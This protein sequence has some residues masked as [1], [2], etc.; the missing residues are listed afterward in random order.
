M[1][2][3]SPPARWQQVSL[4]C[5]SWQT[6]EAT[7]IT[8]LAPLMATAEDARLTACW[9]FSRKGPC[10]RLRIL[11]ATGHDEEAAAFISDLAGR[12]TREQAAERCPQ[13]IYEPEIHAFGGD[14]AMDIAHRLFH[15]DSRTIL[16]HLARDG[17]DHRR[18]LGLILAALLLRAAGQDWYEQGDI[19]RRVAA[20]RRAPTAQ[21]PPPGDAVQTLITANP[22][23]VAPLRSLPEWPAAFEQAGS[24]LAGLARD[25]H[26]TRGLRAVLAH[27]VL[28]AWNRLGL[29]AADQH[30]LAVAAGNV[31]FGDA[32]VTSPPV[33][34]TPTTA[35]A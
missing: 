13:G 2:D 30:H 1:R 24:E 19:W 26:L 21:D 28:F 7:A 22:A 8:R 23:A 12:V 3:T 4:C 9:W 27:H 11:P 18:E 34:A 35:E 31:V 17:P 15:A 16:A 20:H 25:G 10:W 32:P 33:P 5:A 29:P 6:A 14:T